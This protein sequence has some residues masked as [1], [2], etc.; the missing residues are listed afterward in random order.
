VGCNPA[1]FN[2]ETEMKKALMYRLAVVQ[3]AALGL[4]AQAHAALPEAVST[5]ITTYKTDALAA[6]GLIIA[7]GVA[8]WGLLKLA[9]KLG[10]R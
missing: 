2:L 9:S 7:A 3:G 6:A 8:I 1:P 4:A 5:E 10:W